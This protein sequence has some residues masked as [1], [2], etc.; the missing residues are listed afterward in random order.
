MKLS[1]I[2]FSGK[3]ISLILVTVLL[4]GGTAFGSAYYFFS[5]AFDEESENRVSLTATAVQG[6]L[7]DKLEK[8][9][10]NAESFSTRPD[11]ID[12]VAAKI[13][14][15]ECADE[16]QRQGNARD[17]S[18]PEVTQE[19][20]DNPDHQ[21]NSDDESEFNVVNRGPNRTGAVD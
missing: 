4:V 6:V 19:N 15:P 14:H 9:K 20:K 8:V 10:R 17:Q 7:D 21:Y 3:M 5:K 11:M 12:A 2:S 16:R 13:H 1:P 18:G